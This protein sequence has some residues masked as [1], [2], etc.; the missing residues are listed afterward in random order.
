VEF[1][2][3]LQGKVAVPALLERVL[4]KLASRAAPRLSGVTQFAVI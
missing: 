3:D 1:P 2:D 4:Q